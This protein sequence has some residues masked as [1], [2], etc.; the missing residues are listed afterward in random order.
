MSKSIPTMEED[1]E[2]LDMC[3]EMLRNPNSS[4][5]LVREAMGASILIV[6]DRIKEIDSPVLSIEITEEEY[7]KHFK[8]I[9]IKHDV[10][11][12]KHLLLPDLEED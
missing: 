7:N 8:E 10:T 6:Q 3:V 12:Y 5:E 2:M 4:S 11:R 9:F 1:L